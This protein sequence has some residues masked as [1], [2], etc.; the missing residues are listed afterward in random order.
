MYLKEHKNQRKVSE[1]HIFQNKVCQKK[2]IPSQFNQMLY[3]LKC[4][5]AAFK[6]SI[7]HKI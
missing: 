4:K 5:S 2:F 6:Q 3:Y 1:L 7:Y